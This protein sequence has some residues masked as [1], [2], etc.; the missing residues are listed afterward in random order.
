MSYLQH[1][2][3]DKHSECDVPCRWA[4]YP[5]APEKLQDLFE[6]GY[7]DTMTWL[8][9]NGKLAPGDASGQ[10][11]HAAPAHGGFA[12]T[13]SR[14]GFGPAVAQ[15]AMEAPSCDESLKDAV[16][17]ELDARREADHLC[18][19]LHIPNTVLSVLC[20]VWKGLLD[21]RHEY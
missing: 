11:G 13:F 21:D 12:K 5:P 14:R 9:D 1:S 2:S 8:R 7:N 18:M 16:A 19:T 20:I 15:A 3:F 10:N 17:G 6:L 4:A